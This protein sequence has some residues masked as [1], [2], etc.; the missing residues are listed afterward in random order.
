MMYSW[1]WFGACPLLLCVHGPV[2]WASFEFDAFAENK[3]VAIDKKKVVA[4]F[5]YGKIT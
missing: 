2:F 1:A 5:F 3:V 4:S